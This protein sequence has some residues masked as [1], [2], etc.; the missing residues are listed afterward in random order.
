MAKLNLD[1]AELN[2]ETF[3]TAPGVASDSLYNSS[4]RCDT[5]QECSSACFHATNI[6]RLCE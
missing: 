1:L 4:D 5:D 2:V 3:P 6:C